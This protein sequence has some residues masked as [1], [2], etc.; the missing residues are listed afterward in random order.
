[1][2]DLNEDV[3]GVSV[4]TDGLA[5]LRRLASGMKWT[6]ILAS[7]LYLIYLTNAIVGLLGM[8]NSEHWRTANLPFYIE[9]KL[10]LGYVLL[11]AGLNLFQ[12]YLLLSF[13]RQC[14]VACQVADS[15]S[16]NDSLRMLVRFNR[17]TQ[18]TFLLALVFG[19]IEVW[20]TFIFYS[21]LR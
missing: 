3:L 13:S 10:H 7:L 8:R 18:I 6:L 2:E 15:Q 1:M 20:S 19:V 21:M 17:I 11:L 9:I 16:F 12:L 14:V 4:S 5:C